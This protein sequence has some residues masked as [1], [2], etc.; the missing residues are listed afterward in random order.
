MAD[1]YI[2]VAV[3]VIVNDSQRVL[4]AKR[5]D[6]VHQGG[7]WEFPG[8]KV[9]A[10]ESVEQ[11]LLREIK[12]EL[13]IVVREPEPLIKIKHHYND[14]SVLL[15]VWRIKNYSGDPTGAEG[16]AIKWKSISEL[17]AKEF[18]P[19]NKTIIN[20]LQLAD[21]YMI[22]GE[23]D[24]NE[25]FKIKLKKSLSHGERIVQLRCKQM[26]DASC[27]LELANI[28]KS[29]CN[30][31]NAKL[32]LNTGV[33]NFN[34]TTADGLHLNSRLLFQYKNRP[35]ADNK[36]LSISCHNEVEIKQARLLAADIILLSPVKATSSH[37]GVKAMGWQKFNTLLQTSECPVYALG[38]MRLADKERAK[39][40]GAQ[41]VA[42][43][44]SLWH[45]AN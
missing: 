33:D 10:E 6:D 38:G 15:D 43:I 5:A 18:P 4:I 30:K 12:E 21:L 20:A 8:G 44:T 19:A 24:S 22:T 17:D 9:E 27:Y 34:L 37:P 36:L 13:N 14:K 7:L 41:G 40:A 23:F 11:A 25:D 35:I 16:Q 2:H 42:A 28:A 29:I 31:F 32:L 45:S 26:R 1:D 39:H 3:A